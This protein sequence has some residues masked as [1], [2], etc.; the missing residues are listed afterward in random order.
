M[1]CKVQ[2]SLGTQ[3]GSNEPRLRQSCCAARS[4]GFPLVL[5]ACEMRLAMKPYASMDPTQR[6]QSCNCPV[7]AQANHPKLYRR[8]QGLLGRPD[9]ASCLCPSGRPGGRPPLAIGMVP[10]GSGNGLAASLGLWDAAT[11][12]LA[13]VKRATKAMDVA[14]VLQPPSSRSVLPVIGWMPPVGSCACP[15]W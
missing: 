9:W 7:W 6:T 8:A 2:K 11:A 5:P 14:S 15:K 13:V 4:A 10:T 12:A 1:G 3:K